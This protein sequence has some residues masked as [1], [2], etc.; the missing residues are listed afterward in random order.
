MK[1]FALYF[2]V[3]FL[4]HQNSFSQNIINN[5]RG[6]DRSGH[7][8]ESGLLNEWPE[9][10]P[11]MVW[12]FEELGI[13]FTSPVIENGR[14]YVSGME[15][16]MG[17]IYIL[18]MQG[19]LKAKYPYGNEISSR[20][21]GTRSTPTIAGNLMYVATGNGELICMDLENG[22]INW[23]RDLF[24]DFDGSNIRWGFTENLVIAGDLIYCAP[25]GDEFNIVALNRHSGEP[26]WS[27]T[28]EGGLSAYCS[29][30]IID[31]NGQQ[32]L[33]TIMQRNI[34]GMDAQ[35]GELLWSYPYANMRNIHPNTPVYYQ[36][37]IYYFSGYGEGGLKLRLSDDG[38]D[39]SLVWENGTVDP[40]LGG[41]VLV[42]GYLYASGDRNRR[43][44]TID[45]QSGE[46]TYETRE[47]D[48]GNII[49]ADG[50]LYVYTERGELAL[51]E[52]LDGSFRVVSE[53][54]IT[55]GSD[56]HWAHLVIDD[57]ILYVRRGNALMAFDIRQS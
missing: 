28:G 37:D 5:W 12:A 13:G 2:L 23:S 51:L 9:G 52:P 42:D 49:A 34:L 32:I 35:T 3:L 43:W 38:R 1:K 54:D 26:E 48:K 6:P 22:N 30:L 50:M 27:S 33:T 8:H 41:A 25:G 47:I 19:E 18:S 31:H 7:Y 56:Q 44:F 15:G 16:D 17:Y 11:E 21:P 55:L 45:W 10:G 57:G 29:P 14:I 53:T 39:V 20:Y 36:G 24:N 4:I 46:I 40:Q